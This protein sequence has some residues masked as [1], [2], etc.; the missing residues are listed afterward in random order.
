MVR[1]IPS[2]FLG[3]DAVYSGKEL[4][5]SVVVYLDST[6]IDN[7]LYFVHYLMDPRVVSNFGHMYKHFM[8]V[9]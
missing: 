5:F 9:P 3:Y 6:I 7:H 1:F 2:I 4:P 8:S